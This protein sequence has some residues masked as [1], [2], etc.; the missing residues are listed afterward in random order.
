M[1]RIAQAM[2]ISRSRLVERAT[3]E[4]KARPPRY[5]K[6]EDEFLL[7]II[8][9]ILDEKST[10][11]YRRVCALLNRRLAAMGRPRVNHKRV[12]RIMRLHGLL[13]SR[14]TGKRPDRAHE[15]KV[16][17]IR[18]NVRWCSDVF[19]IGCDNGEA[20][21]VAFG[22]DCCDRECMSYVASSRGIS[23]G[24]IRDLM[25][26]CVERRFGA[27]RT[28]HSVQWLSDNGSCFTAKETVEFA[29][30]LGLESCFTPVRSPESNGMAEA[31]VKTFKRDYV[32]VNPRPDAKTVLAHLAAW[33]EDYN[34]IHPHKGLRMQS[35]R[36]F[37]R[38]SKTAECPV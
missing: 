13:L 7:P 25:L 33:F 14:H 19:E 5:A 18:R 1:T 35:P 32:N 6:A 27:S 9:D 16:I 15:G 36:E 3:A 22:L 30:W 21:R 38:S 8:R 17:A 2:D 26:D 34:E 37:I 12:Y 20:V 24:M 23:G 4:P 29:S 28:P 10:Y 31:F 11:G